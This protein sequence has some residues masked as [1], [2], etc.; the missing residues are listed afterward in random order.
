MPRR[1]TSGTSVVPRV[2][3]VGSSGVV[4]VASPSGR[5]WQPGR[6]SCPERGPCVSFGAYLSGNCAMNGTTQAV[7]RSADGGTTWPEPPWPSMVDACT[8]AELFA[9]SART[10][11]LVSSGSPFLLRRSTDA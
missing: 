2:G 7:L 3:L 9:T 6:F 5:S 1:A 4:E 11:L 10:E 8:P